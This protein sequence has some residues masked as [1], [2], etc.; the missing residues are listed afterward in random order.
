MIRSPAYAA[1]RYLKTIKLFFSSEAKGGAIGWFALLL[2]LLLAVNSLNVI[3]SYVGRDF[4]TAV[5]DRR[6]REFIEYGVL[7]AG[8]FV[9]SSIVAAFYRFSEERLRLLWRAW[10]TGTTHR[11]LPLEQHVLSTS[12]RRR[13][14]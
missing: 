12:G 3:N 9:A 5:S 8:V 6:M 4:M 11:S 10:L 7:Y 13:T 1:P 14:G 2:C